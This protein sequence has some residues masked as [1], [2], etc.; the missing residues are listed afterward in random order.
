MKW[1][2]PAGIV[3]APM[4]Q[5]FVT[6]FCIIGNDFITFSGLGWK[7][8]RRETLWSCM[9]WWVLHQQQNK[10]FSNSNHWWKKRRSHV[11]HVCVSVF[12]QDSVPGVVDLSFPRPRFEELLSI[13]TGSWS[14]LSLSLRRDGKLQIAWTKVWGLQLECF[15]NLFHVLCCCQKPETQ[16]PM[17]WA[18]EILRTD[19]WKKVSDFLIETWST[20][21]RL[22]L[23]TRPY[24]Q[25]TK[26]RSGSETTVWISCHP[27]RVLTWT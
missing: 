10:Q 8:G 23:Q 27:A 1:M 9:L 16:E 12:V 13:T 5:Q 24:A 22:G 4:L 11:W 17:S 3:F 18:A 2:C 19:G 14:S 15:A 21:A 20:A 6:L 26:D 7:P 25:A